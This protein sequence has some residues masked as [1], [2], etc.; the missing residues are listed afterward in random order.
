MW[1]NKLSS[2]QNTLESGR[3]LIMVLEADQITIFH[4]R[5]RINLT[6]RIVIHILKVIL[7]SDALSRHWSGQNVTLGEPF[8]SWI[9]FTVFIDVIIDG[10]SVIQFDS[11]QKG[12][13][14]G[15]HVD[16]AKVVFIFWLRMVVS[17][18]LKKSEGTFIDGVDECG[19]DAVQ[20]SNYYAS[21]LERYFHALDILPQCDNRI[22]MVELS[23]VSMLA[24]GV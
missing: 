4:P 8:S 15:V 10:M 19:V 1:E 20:I 3:L 16:R 13:V 23:K 22:T 5:T 21:S 24:G 11:T 17:T 9:S 2:K 14:F 6:F 7:T 12:H 18:K